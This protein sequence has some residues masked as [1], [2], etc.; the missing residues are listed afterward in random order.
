MYVTFTE[1]TIFLQS[2]C[3]VPILISFGNVNVLEKK[4]NEKTGKRT[5][6]N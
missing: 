2:T 4:R 3:W 1:D 5:S 6:G